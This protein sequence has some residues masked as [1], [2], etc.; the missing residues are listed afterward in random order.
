MLKSAAISSTKNNATIEFT[1]D[2]YIENVRKIG[3]E[4]QKRTLSFVSRLSCSKWHAKITFEGTLQSAQSTATF[5][6]AQKRREDLESLC[7]HIDFGDI[8]LLDNTVTELVVTRVQNAATQRLRL[9][10]ALD[11]TNE[12][13]PIASHLRFQV[14]EDPSRVRF[15]SFNN[16]G[17]IRTIDLSEIRKKRRLSAG[18]HVVDVIGDME[19]YVYKEIDKPLYQPRHTKVLEQELLNLLRLRHAKTIVRL[20]FAV[21]SRYPYQTAEI[22]EENNSVFLRG[23]LIEYHPNGTLQDALLSQKVD[24]PWGRWALQ[25]SIAVDELHQCA[26]AHM[27]LKPGN[28]VISKD[29]NV[30]LIDVSGIGATH[31][32][33]SPEMRDLEDPL[34]ERIESRKQNDI[35]ALGAIL[36]KMANASRND[37]EKQVLQNV[38]VGATIEDPRS[39][40]SS[41]KVISELVKASEPTPVN[42]FWVK[43]PVC[44]VIYVVLAFL[45][46]RFGIRKND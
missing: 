35:W 3:T 43:P 7:G 32:W 42:V 27:D 25:L 34:S 23:I 28:A 30:V 24:L 1:P 22:Y 21:V 41:R 2:S 38:A 15:P 20:V 19:L 44:N 14:Q 12:Y 26:V 16:G 10:T 4:P 13:E 36:S 45:R 11:A 17:N 37:T 6:K 31:E 40:I 33:L 18:V 39:R 29:N 46:D 8:Q 9:K 5:A